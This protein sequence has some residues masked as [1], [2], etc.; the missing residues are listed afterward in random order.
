M[1]MEEG[2]FTDKETGKDTQEQ[3]MPGLKARDNQE[4]IVEKNKRDDVCQE[5]CSSQ[6]EPF[7]FKVF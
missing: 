6:R 7:T 5:G 1:R 3:D 2:R 4:W